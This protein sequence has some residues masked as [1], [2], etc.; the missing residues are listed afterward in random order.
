MKRAVLAAFVGLALIAIPD[1]ALGHGV[2]GRSDLPLSL[3]LVSYAAGAV[4]V[5]TFAALAWLWP[6]ARWEKGIHGRTLPDTVQALLRFIALP[7]RLTGALVLGV[8][9]Y[10][11]TTGPDDPQR[12]IAPVVVYVVFWVGFLFA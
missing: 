6:I 4:L 9:L 10:A 5:V 12:N 3:S 11:A 8:V 1:V 7:L 2:S